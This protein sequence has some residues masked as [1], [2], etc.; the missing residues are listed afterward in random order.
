MYS[1]YFPGSWLT[2]IILNDY[3]FEVLVTIDS[4]VKSSIVHDFQL[5]SEK[6]PQPG[7]FRLHRNRTEMLL[8][9]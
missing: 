2:D 9:P 7:A 5:D 4:A 6:N 1:E 3:E 8:Y